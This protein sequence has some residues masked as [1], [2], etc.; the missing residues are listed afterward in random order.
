MKEEIDFSAFSPTDYRYAV[1]ELRDYLSEEAF[2]NYK[3]KVEAAVASAFERRG[4]LKAK[5]CD[6]IVEAASKVKA[7]EVYEEEKRTKH[8]IRAL[9]NVIRSGVSDEA[10]PFVH[11]SATSYDV[12]NTANALRYKDAVMKV[13]IPDMVELERTWIDLARRE[14]DTLQIG[15]THG[16]HAEPIT[17]GFALAQYVNRWGSQIL[18]VQ[19]TSK[20]L[21][22]KFSGAV[23]A[24][25]AT[26]LIF[27]DPEE[28]EREV[29]AL[30]NMKPA[31]ISTQIVPPEPVSDFV[32][33]IISSFSVLANFCDDM[34]HLQRSEIGEIF[35]RVAKEQVG[36]STMPHKRNPIS[37]EGVKSL[38]K[39]FMPQAVTMHLDQ[40][41]EHQRDLTNSASQRYTQELLVVFNHCVRKLRMISARLV[42]DRARMR[43][44]FMISADNIIAEPLYIL[45]SYYG[46]PDAHEYVRKKSFQAYEGKKTLRE[47][48]E[49][50]EEIISY[51][52]K[53]SREQKEKVFDAEKYMGIAAEKAEKVADYWEGVFKTN[54]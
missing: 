12:V 38:W 44:N 21:I 1:D 42:V 6:E 52:R 39:T 45:L 18:N 23:G 13:I 48:I 46:H 34:R 20:N 47:V 9:V 7:E 36:S 11:L 8:D 2:V 25:N 10:K 3:A 30:L 17:F 51:L 15:R 19:E 27:D 29:L 35:E 16:Q 33:S 26:S 40:I 43:E 22:G 32:H 14:K 37:F 49:R 28:F 53:F 5:L 4:I 41:S 24:Y 54:F 31:A 50:D